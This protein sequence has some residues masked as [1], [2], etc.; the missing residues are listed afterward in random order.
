[1]PLHD[2]QCLACGTIEP[3]VMV[4]GRDYGP[5]QACGGERTWLP[6][7]VHTDVCGSEQI[8]PMLR[9]EMGQVLTYTST[10]ERDQKMARLGFSPA[11]DKVGG[12]R[13]E[14]RYKQSHFSYAGQKRGKRTPREPMRLRAS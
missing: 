1:M 10:R 8:A 9:D 2:V 11:G 14:D 4:R 7:V 5:C 13:N 3:N 12:A 6:F